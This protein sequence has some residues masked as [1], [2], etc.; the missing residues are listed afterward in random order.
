MNL[1]MLKD[2]IIREIVA[3]IDERLS[4]PIGPARAAHVVALPVR[5]QAV[6]SRCSGPRPCK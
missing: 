6:N 1:T 4:V 2:V 3:A 5:R